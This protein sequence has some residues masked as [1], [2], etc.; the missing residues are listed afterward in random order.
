M[1]LSAFSEFSICCV[2]LAGGPKEIAIR[3]PH[4]LALALPSHGVSKEIL[5]NSFTSLCT[6]DL[7][8]FIPPFLEK[9]EGSEPASFF[10]VSHHFLFLLG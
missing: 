10:T 8:V 7:I 9:A 4:L 2:L 3:Y 1:K 5:A 6:L